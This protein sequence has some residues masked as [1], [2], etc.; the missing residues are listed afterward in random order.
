[1]FLECGSDQYFDENFCVCRCKAPGYNIIHGKCEYTGCRQDQKY[2]E[3]H[4][5]NCT[6]RQFGYEECNGKCVFTGW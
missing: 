5:K 4:E 1:M 3:G 2:V 6:C